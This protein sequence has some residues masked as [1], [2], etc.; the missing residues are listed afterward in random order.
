MIEARIVEANDAFSR[1]L[2]VRLGIHDSGP[3]GHR[4]LGQNSPR[5]HARRRPRGHRLPYRPDRDH[6]GLLR[7]RHQ[8]QPAGRGPERVRRRPVLVHPVQQRG[9][10]LPQPGAHRAGGRRQGQDHL[11]PARAHRRPGRGADRAGHGDPVPAGDLLAAP[12]RVVPQGQP[13]AQGEA[14]DHARRQRDHD[15]RREQGSARARPRRPACRST[16]ST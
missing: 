2:G 16:P 15:A 5:L 1:N 3:A 9:D 10:A 7:Q 4:V 13:V 12:P 14:A 6:A 8:R 11:Q